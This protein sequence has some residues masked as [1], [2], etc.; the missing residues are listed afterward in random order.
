MVK[1]K[2]GRHAAG[3][4][5]A[6]SVGDSAQRHNTSAALYGASSFLLY[7]ELF[8]CVHS[9]R[10][11]GEEEEEEESHFLPLRSSLSVTF[12]ESH[13]G[14][15]CKDIWLFKWMRRPCRRCSIYFVSVCKYACGVCA[16]VE[17]GVCG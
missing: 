5:E 14:H 17:C 3:G 4:W 16:C 13:W 9:V 10:R 6:W 1:T 15:M 8:A 7:E 12:F 11:E 2:A